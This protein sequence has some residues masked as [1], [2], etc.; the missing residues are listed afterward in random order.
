MAV[1]WTDSIKEDIDRIES[2]ILETIHSDNAELDEMCRYVIQSGGKRVRPIVCLLCHLALGGTDKERAIRIGSAFEIVHSAT[3]IHDD[4]NDQGEMRR[5]RRTLHRE[6]TLTKAIVAGDFMLTR[7]Y[8]A[9][10]SIPEEAMDIIANAASSMSEGEFIQQDFERVATVT[11]E[12][13]FKIINGKTAV[14]IN[15]AAMIGAYLVT[16]DR[17]KL[18]VIDEYASKIGLSFQIIDDTLDIIGSSKDTGTR[19]GIDMTE[20]KPTLPVI[21]GMQDP[22]HGDEI[23]S[24]YVRKDASS[25]DI[26][27]ALDLIKETDSIE[28]C[29]KA[30]ER[31][32]DEAVTAIRK[33]PES[34][35]RDSL[36][37]LARYIVSRDR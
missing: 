35:Y 3:L 11:E 33:L 22:K 5:G 7:G 18:S 4:I 32:A 24:I 14:L 10:G 25:D 20:G 1:T 6:Y 26:M 31:L 15:A 27:H 36:E 34:E 19:V 8:K 30:A 21:Y 12:D 2:Y 16:R 9:M 37:G 29:R 23:R 13:Y 28:R 17:E